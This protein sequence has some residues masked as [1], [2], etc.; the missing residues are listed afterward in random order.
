[1]EAGAEPFG[2]VAVTR[3]TFSPTGSIS[4]S[5]PTL[6]AVNKLSPDFQ[7]PIVKTA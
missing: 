1:M 5:L 6:I 3:I 4:Q 7:N 2:E